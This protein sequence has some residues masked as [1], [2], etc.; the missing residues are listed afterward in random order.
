MEFKI[1]EKNQA[2]RLGALCQ[3]CSA[4]LQRRTTDLDPNWI[5]EQRPL[6]DKSLRAHLARIL[7]QLDRKESTQNKARTAAARNGCSTAHVGMMYTLRYKYI[8]P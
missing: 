5:E 1:V 4:L 6:S 8:E 2:M 7:P 3:T